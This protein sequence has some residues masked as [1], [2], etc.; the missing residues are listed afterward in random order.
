MQW[1]KGVNCG[2][3][4]KVP[5]TSTRTVG[6]GTLGLVVSRDELRWTIMDEM[7]REYIEEQEG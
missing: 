6:V 7:I 4:R 2:C 1:M 5:R 3:C